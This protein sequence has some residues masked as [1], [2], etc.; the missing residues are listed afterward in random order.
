MKSFTEVLTPEQKE[1]F[2]NWYFWD[3][4]TDLFKMVNNENDELTAENFRVIFIDGEEIKV[5]TVEDIQFYDPEQGDFDFIFND[6]ENYFS[7]SSAPEEVVE[8]LDK[9]LNKSQY[10]K[11]E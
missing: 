1:C 10:E 4:N 11:K 5:S 3:N 8:F 9:Y 7:R 6:N 2:K